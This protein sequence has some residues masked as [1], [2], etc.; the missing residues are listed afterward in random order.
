[1]YKKVSMN[2]YNTEYVRSYI[3]EQREKRNPNNKFEYIVWCGGI[4]VCNSFLTLKQA[5]ST[6]I[7]YVNDDYDDVYIE[8]LPNGY[9]TSDD[10]TQQISVI[11]YSDLTQVKYRVGY[12]K[13]QVISLI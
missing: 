5:I 8:H 9:E 11:D 13:I 7:N 6:Y 10:D 3:N 1:M 12:G 2:V 4:E